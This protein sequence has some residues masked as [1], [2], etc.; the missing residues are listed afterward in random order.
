PMDENGNYPLDPINAR[1]PNPYSLLTIKAEGRV[2]RIL[3][4]PSLEIKPFERLTFQVKA[5]IDR[6]ASKRWKS[7]PKTTLHGDADRA[8]ASIASSDNNSYLTECTGNYIKTFSSDH[9]VNILA[10]ASKQRF[11]NESES[12]LNT[13]FLSDEFLWYNI[14]SGTG[15]PTVASSGNE[16]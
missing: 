6:G 3:L 5:V 8:R 12:L 13:T 14:G 7:W 4:N 2:E 1:R 10:G 11:R 9:N 15:F 16:N